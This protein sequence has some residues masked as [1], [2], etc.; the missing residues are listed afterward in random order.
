MCEHPLHKWNNLLTIF[1]T[2]KSH[3]YEHHI[4]NVNL[5][6]WLETIQKIYF[7]PVIDSFIGNCEI[8]IQYVVSTNGYEVEQIKK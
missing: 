7:Y 1:S 4:R 3:L 5:Q 8:K 6:T 2:G